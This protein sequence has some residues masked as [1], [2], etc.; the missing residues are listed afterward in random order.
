MKI[1]GNN[2]SGY[3]IGGSTVSAIYLGTTKVY[4]LVTNTP[5][6]PVV[7]FRDTMVNTSGTNQALSTNLGW[8]LFYGSTTSNTS[9]GGWS[10]A[11]T[12][13][14]DSLPHVNAG[15]TTD[16]ST[17]IIWNNSSSDRTITYTS[18]YVI[19]RTSDEVYQ[20][21]F[22]DAHDLSTMG[23]YFVFKIGTQWYLYDEIQMATGG[24]VWK[25]NTILMD[26]ASTTKFRIL[27]F[28]ESSNTAMGIGAITTPP[29]GNIDK[30]G[31]YV[32]RASVASNLLLLDELEI[33]MIAR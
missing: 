27:N 2:I 20:V 17:G 18:K 3:Q 28:T 8:N 6:A 22:Y 4:E 32:T 33:Q 30:V 24:R 12:G 19:D 15:Y 21:S 14:S 23:T 9:G 5:A 26:M 10:S 16:A 11:G 25:K 7:V 31:L 13:A 29:A 1:G